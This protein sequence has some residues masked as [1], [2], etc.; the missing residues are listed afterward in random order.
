MRSSNQ[1]FQDY[2][3]YFKDI[4]S[5]AASY[6]RGSISI[7]SCTHRKLKKFQTKMSKFHGFFSTFFFVI[8]KVIFICTKLKCS[9]KVSRNWFIEFPLSRYCDCLQLLPSVSKRVLH[10]LTFVL[11]VNSFQKPNINIISSQS[12]HNTFWCHRTQD[13]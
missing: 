12:I 8:L 5:D 10:K 6:L 2:L 13:F 9:N 11:R 1:K 4:W 3:F 7:F